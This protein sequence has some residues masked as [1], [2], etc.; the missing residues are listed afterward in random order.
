MLLSEW[1]ARA[2]GVVARLKELPGD[3]EVMKVPGRI[4]LDYDGTIL[5]KIN[6]GEMELVIYGDETGQA[7]ARRDESVQHHRGGD[8]GEVQP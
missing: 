7:G 6:C 1:V 4:V 8:G 2:E 3:I 5:G